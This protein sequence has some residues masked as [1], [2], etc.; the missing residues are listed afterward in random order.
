MGLQITAKRLALLNGENSTDTFYEIDDIVNESGD[1]TGTKVSLK[2]RYKE[3][4][5]EL[6]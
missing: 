5:E 2:I 6:V 3:S 1:V 4:I